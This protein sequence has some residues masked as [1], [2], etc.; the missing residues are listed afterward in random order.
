M[1]KTKKHLKLSA[2]IIIGEGPHDKAFLNHLKDLYDSR[3]SGQ[4]ITIETADGGSPKDIIRSAFKNKHISYDYRCV[5]MDSDIPLSD[6][7]KNT[8]KKYKINI[9]QSRPICLEGMLLEVLNQIAPNT[10]AKC[11]A[12]LH[13]QLSG[14][15]TEKESYRIQFTKPILD[16]SSKQ[17]IIKLKAILSNA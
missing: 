15:P 8:A 7:N 1:R 10:N 4:K 3:T 16:V 17:E 13:P 5:L 12:L 2:L 14:K 6:E 9:I 11:K